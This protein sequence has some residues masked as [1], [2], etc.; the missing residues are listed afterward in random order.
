MVVEEEEVA[1]AAEEVAVVDGAIEVVLVVE[2]ASIE[3]GVVEIGGVAVDEE[4]VVVGAVAA[5]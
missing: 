4:D 2:G 3:A 1:V 5:F